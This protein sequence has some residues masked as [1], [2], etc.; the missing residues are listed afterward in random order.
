M[1]AIALRQKV[2]RGRDESGAVREAVLQFLNRSGVDSAT[3][4]K[5][6]LILEE[7][8]VNL[9]WHAFDDDLEHE[10]EIG[11]ELDG[12]QLVIVISDDGVAF[13]P[14]QAP[15]PARPTSLHDAVPGGLGL[16]LVRKFAQSVTYE[17][18]DARNR[19]TICLAT[20]KPGT[21][22]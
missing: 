13:D 14:T 6:E 9:A 7:T 10:V 3:V 2:A 12:S 8:F 17:R 15:E 16:I 11:I 1:P 18:R 19:L 20:D 5:V 21:V 22:S 4:F